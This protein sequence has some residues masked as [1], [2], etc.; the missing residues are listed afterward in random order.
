MGAQTEPRTGEAGVTP[1]RILLAEDDEDMRAL[2]VW[3]LRRDGY[4]VNECRDGMEFYGYLERSVLAVELADFD[5]VVS[6]IRMPGEFALDVLDEFEGCDGLPP[7]ILITAF[8]D[9]A[10]YAEA[11]QLGVVMVFD[12]PFEMEFLME[13]ICRLAPIQPSRARDNEV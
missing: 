1:P 4:E 7:A 12:K 6:D 9:S 11:R 3:R 13:E 8:G 10:T 2:L 5:L